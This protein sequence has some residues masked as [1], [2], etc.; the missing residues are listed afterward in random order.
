MNVK[1][2]PLKFRYR[3]S[4]GIFVLEDDGGNKCFIGQG[5]S[6]AV[7]HQNKPQSQGLVAKGPIP[8]GLWQLGSAFKHARLGEVAIP[9][10]PKSQETALGRSGFYIHGDNQRADGTAS[11][12]CII[13]NRKSR[14]YIEALRRCGVS[15]L[16]VID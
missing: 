13:L 14:D 9:I 6:G 11:S 10:W 2:Y 1:S 8:R 7:G 16:I 4:T 15:S 12:G 5:Y 3:I